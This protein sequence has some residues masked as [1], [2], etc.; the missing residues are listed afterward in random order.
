MVKPRLVSLPFHA[1][2]GHSMS[3]HGV[4]IRL[5]Q[6]M[7]AGHTATAINFETNVHGEKAMGQG[8]HPVNAVLLV[9]TT[10]Q[11]GA[12]LRQLDR[13]PVIAAPPALPVSDALHQTSRAA[14]RAAG[15]HLAEAR[16]QSSV[17][18]IDRNEL[19]LAS[20][21]A[22]LD[23]V[24]EHIRQRSA[25]HIV[26]IWDPAGLM[27]PI[28]SARLGLQVIELT[29]DPERV[30]QTLTFG[31]AIDVV[32][33]TVRSLKERNE[34]LIRSWGIPAE[35]Q[36]RINVDEMTEQDVLGRILSFFGTDASPAMIR[37]L[38][39]S[40]LDEGNSD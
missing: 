17:S 31:P 4:P 3:V 39:A 2:S 18:V 26:L 5:G 23:S 40:S 21:T 11:P 27:F 38:T 35:R 36:C 16:R 33:D 22:L 37:S 13:H 12:L 20:G 14:A 25:K 29:S 9:S 19:A 30:A 28:R 6:P 34:Q 24:F 10:N 8:G 7:G 15:A 32:A 1:M